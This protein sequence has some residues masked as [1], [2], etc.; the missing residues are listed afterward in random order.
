[1]DVLLL[2]LVIY[3]HEA[4]LQYSSQFLRSR[5]VVRHSKSLVFAQIYSKCLDFLKEMHTFSRYFDFL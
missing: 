3:L 5:L 4:Y 2:Q 1:M